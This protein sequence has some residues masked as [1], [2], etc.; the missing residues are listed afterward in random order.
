[1]KKLAKLAL[2]TALLST[3]LLSRA[4]PAN[5]CFHV[6]NLLCTVGHHCEIIGGCA[7]CVPN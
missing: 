1:M 2:A 3:A 5:A 4:Q 6:C 7:T